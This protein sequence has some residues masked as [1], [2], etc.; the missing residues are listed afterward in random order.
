MQPQNLVLLSL[1]EV[2]PDHLS[3]YGYEKIRTPYLDSVA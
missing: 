2:R 1:D 3:C